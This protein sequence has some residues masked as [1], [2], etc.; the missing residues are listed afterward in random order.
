MALHGDQSG[1]ER[2]RHSR[3][4]T[5]RET[6]LVIF[7]LRKKTQLRAGPPDR[8][9][10]A[11]N[12]GVREG[13]GHSGLRETPMDPNATPQ[14]VDNALQALE[15]TRGYL[16]A[17]IDLL[18]RRGDPYSRRLIVFCI[19]GRAGKRLLDEGFSEPVAGSWS[20]RAVPS[21]SMHFLRTPPTPSTCMSSGRSNWRKG[22]CNDRPQRHPAIRHR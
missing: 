22:R 9:T 17:A 12:A 5:D 1:R 16:P 14:R 13:A 8:T 18:R 20:S 10:K 6:G 11:G 15:E 21:V 4:E 3:L 2:A 7:G 19:F